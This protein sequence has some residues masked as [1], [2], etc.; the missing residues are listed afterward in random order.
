MRASSVSIPPTAELVR[1]ATDDSAELIRLELALARDEL[2]RDLIAVKSSVIAGAAAA[3]AAL[4]G[5]VALVLSLGLALGAYGALAF[6]VV[7][8]IIA[9]GLGVWAAHNFP[10][11]PLAATARRLEAD[12]NVLK[13]QVT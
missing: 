3:L 6:G 13:E 7:F 11:H 2:R 8:L 4:L 9:V 1:R 5:L 12:E 10:T